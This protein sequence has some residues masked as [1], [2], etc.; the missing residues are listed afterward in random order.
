MKDRFSDPEPAPAKAG[1][2][3]WFKKPE[4]SEAPILLILS[5]EQQWGETGRTQDYHYG[6]KVGLLEVAWL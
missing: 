1:M 6:K 2:P 4:Q 5:S 3:S